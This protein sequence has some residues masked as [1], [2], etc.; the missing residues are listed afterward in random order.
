MKSK[1]YT[2]APESDKIRRAREKLQQKLLEDDKLITPEALTAAIEKIRRRIER[3]SGERLSLKDKSI[4]LF[5]ENVHTAKIRSPF[6]KKLEDRIAADFANSS[7][8][9][10]PGLK[11]RIA[12]KKPS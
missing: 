12:A 9:S 2:M 8:V 11:G 7:E 5:D 1:K 10:L 3:H 4:T 6:I